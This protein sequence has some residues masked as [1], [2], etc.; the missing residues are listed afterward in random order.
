MSN[1]LH[2][3]MVHKREE[4][5]LA[6]MRTPIS[7]LEEAIKYVSKPRGFL[8][9]LQVRRAQNR[10]GIIAEIKKAS[11][12]K[13]VIREDFDPAR[14][15]KAYEEGGAAC[16]SVLTDVKFF[17]GANDY[18]H[19]AR[20]ACALPALR[21]DFLCD[22]YQVFEA[23]ALGADCILIIMAAVDDACARDLLNAA[24]AL[25]MDVLV[26]THNEAE[27][28]RAIALKAPLIGINNRNLQDFSVDLEIS[29]K[30]ARLAPPRILLVSES[31][32]AS[33]ADIGRLSKSGINTFLI[34]ETLMKQADVSKTLAAL[35]F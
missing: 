6:K 11:P 16:L 13:G 34:G 27:M 19:Q 25:Q 17:Q 20:E 28:R 35:T 31:G 4:I 32:I 26:E 33:R 23:R 15:A 14:L 12:S 22:V 5:A 10:I 2:T 8:H 21:K 9:A 7:E 3:I 30:L 18:L 1:I 29:E 24:K